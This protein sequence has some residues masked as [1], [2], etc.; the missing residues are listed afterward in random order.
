MKDIV[1]Q[2]MPKDRAEAVKRANN[3]K[4]FLEKSIGGK[5]KLRIHKNL[6]WFYS[7]SCGTINVSEYAKS[8]GGGGYSILNGG[9]GAGFGGLGLTVYHP[10][11][12]LQIAKAVRASL[13]EQRKKFENYI[14]WYVKNRDISGYKKLFHE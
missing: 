14:E 8:Y 3:L 5:W 2:K 12:R 1:Y 9:Y 11:T 4:K 7:A 10:S 6:S 13:S